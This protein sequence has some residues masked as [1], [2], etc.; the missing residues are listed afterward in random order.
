[1]E[2]KEKVDY[3]PL[4]SIVILKGGVQKVVIIARGLV[5]AVT[6]PAGF[7]DY[8][9]CL[10]PQGIVGDQIMYFNHSDIAKVDVY[11]RQLAGC[12]TGNYKK[13]LY[14]DAERMQV[15]QHHLNNRGPVSAPDVYMKLA[16]PK[17]SV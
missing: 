11:K 10:Y 12:L 8:G 2:E 7:F 6:T 1:M 4:G 9:G 5:T 15:F 17:D 14:I 3:L 16:D 13:V